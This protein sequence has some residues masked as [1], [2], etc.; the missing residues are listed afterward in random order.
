MSQ[1]QKTATAD[2]LQIKD[3]RDYRMALNFTTLTLA[4]AIRIANDVVDDDENKT[5]RLNTLLNQMPEYSRQYS[6]LKEKYEKVLREYQKLKEENQLGRRSS[7][8][9]LS[10]HLSDGE[11]ENGQLSD[12]ELGQ[13]D[14]LSE[15]VEPD[16]QEDTA[17]DADRETA[18]ETNDGTSGQTSDT[19]STS[20][21]S[22][23]ATGA[24][25]ADSPASDEN[26]A[27][28]NGQGSGE[29]NGGGNN[30]NGEGK[31]KR[32]KGGNPH[33]KP[34]TPDSFARQTAMLPHASIYELDGLRQLM[35]LLGEDA[36]YLSVTFEN[37][38]TV[39]YQ[40]PCLYVQD[41]NTPVFA[42]TEKLI[43]KFAD[44]SFQYQVRRL[45][46]PKH[47]A[48]FLPGSHCSPELAAQ[49]A[50][51][52]VGLYLPAYRIEQNLKD[53]HYPLG[54]ATFLRQ[55]Y[56]AAELY[57][58]PVID[59]L[60]SYLFDHKYIQMDETTWEVIDDGRKQG[61]KSYIW[62][63]ISSELLDCPKAAVYF[64]NENR[65][66][67]FLEDK[68]AD[69]LKDIDDAADAAIDAECHDI[70][71]DSEAG[72]EADSDTA[73]E[74]QNKDK[75][76]KNQNA[77]E[78]DISPD[79][80]RIKLAEIV[81]KTDAFQAYP[82]LEKR[83]NGTIV[84]SFCLAHLRRYFF[85]AWLILQLNMEKPI[86]DEK[87]KRLHESLE[88]QILLEISIAEKEDTKLKK[89]SREERLKGRLT[90]V[91]SHLEKAIALAEN[92][93][94]ED[95]DHARMT[96]TMSKAVTYLLNCKKDGH[97][98]NF[99]NDPDIPCDNSFCE[100]NLRPVAVQRHSSLFSFSTRGAI[101]R[102]VLMSVAETAKLNK[103]NV[104]AYFCYLFSRMPEHVKQKEAIL[105]YMPDMM[106]WSDA[107]REFEKQMNMNDAS[108]YRLPNEKQPHLVHG[109]WSCSA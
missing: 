91:K 109:K 47:A 95:P 94:R 86:D 16:M 97:I 55:L 84:I 8:G 92:A 107:Y 18:P 80:K 93:D 79:G 106:P 48:F 101:E 98:D 87:L 2:G 54:R 99:L 52:Y 15:D 63:I 34:R 81:A 7:F 85:L 57:L 11:I 4:Q 58:A 77:Y 31:T 17:P 76:N 20:S 82:K 32:K 100:R 102:M 29:G 23:K 53:L 39:R 36:R 42:Y 22:D 90:K 74:N 12:K 61:A 50:Y 60:L 6:D 37:H 104:F 56:R 13:Q 89:L 72:P 24:H 45:F 83:S 88:W 5:N 69:F 35:D 68:F 30:G 38:P 28:G 9:V 67:D 40:R 103:A 51:E 19:G 49:I 14:P 44:R 25:G 96:L 65:S 62:L 71:P 3:L 33:P 26:P 1:G 75:T 66:E 46:R 41:L 105:S 59:Y 21:A 43:D 73:A 10:E 70:E 108:V 27:S 78:I 64:Y